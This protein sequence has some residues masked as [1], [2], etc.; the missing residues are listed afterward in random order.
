MVNLFFE[1]LNLSY[2][3]SWIVIAV[4]LIRVVFT[5]APK[6]AKCFL[7]SI[8][9]F[10]LLFPFVDIK[11]AFSI[12]PTSKLLG[13]NELSNIPYIETGVKM[14]DAEVYNYI[15]DNIDNSV[16][17]DYVASENLLVVLAIIW[18]V[19]I[20]VMLVYAG[21][22]YI[23]LNIRVVSSV[24]CKENIYTCDNI[25][26]PFVLGIVKPKIYL[27]A[28]LT[29]IQIESVV[30]HEKAHIKRC[31]QLWKPLGFMLLC[32]HWFNPLMWGA[33]ALLCRDVELACDEKVI[34]EMSLE[35]KKI[36]TETLLDCSMH[37]RLVMACPLAFGEIGVKQRVKSI[38]N[39]KKPTFWIVIIT[40]V[41]ILVSSVCL[42]TNPQKLE[43][44]SE[45]ESFVNKS[46]A[47][48]YKSSKT[49][50]NFIAVDYELFDVEEEGDKTTLYMAAVYQEYNCATELRCE[51]QEHDVTKLVVEKTGVGEY[52]IT[53]YFTPAIE[54]AI[55]FRDIEENFPKS[56]WY[57]AK[58]YHLYIREEKDNC[59]KQAMEYFG[60]TVENL[61]SDIENVSD[62]E[63]E[64]DANVDVPKPTEERKG[65]KYV[66]TETL[67]PPNK[68][69]TTQM[70]TLPEK[71][72][73]KDTVKNDKSEITT[74]EPAT[75][76]EAIEIIDESSD[77]DI[78][79]AYRTSSCLGKDV[80]LELTIP[81]E[82]GYGQ[83]FKVY[84]KVKNITDKPVEYV[85]PSRSPSYPEISLEIHGDGGSFTDINRYMKPY[86]QDRVCKILNPGEEI[87]VVYELCPGKPNG[88][89]AQTSDWTYCSKGK[90]MASV[91]FLVGNLD[92][93][94]AHMGFSISIDVV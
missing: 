18:L 13:V 44:N 19:G 87:N 12:I 7:W 84:A 91:S 20:A 3:A 45:L 22:S 35:D 90:Y 58:Y 1:V 79:L 42:I 55:F 76:E 92:S 72:T 31:D 30:K 93:A 41:A 81:Q 53:E 16:V 47:E 69:S 52:K 54:G 86:T 34:K 60:V 74:T 14:V 8:L 89:T 70:T 46:I 9:G 23:K 6:W 71:T 68:V 88:P 73:N 29:E 28:G 37:R 94:P 24:R 57:E 27:P 59:F 66:E 51:K 10:K 11:S 62:N 36:Y 65:D 85:L 61:N 80:V 48:H 56:L 2:T 32:V 83:R 77:N 21:V 4:I 75:T 39:Y 50:D 82:V 17:N 78:P 5:K 33:F 67:F 40:V 15:A 63:V 25:D 38:V 49:A 43:L 26:T 64:K